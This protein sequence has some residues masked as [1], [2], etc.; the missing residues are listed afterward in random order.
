MQ[1]GHAM[2]VMLT[3]STHLRHEGVGH[4]ELPDKVRDQIVSHPAGH[5]D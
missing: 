4:G 5:I 1:N 2:K 3:V